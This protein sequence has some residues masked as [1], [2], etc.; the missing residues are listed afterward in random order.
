MKSTVGYS[1]QPMSPMAAVALSQGR[2]ALGAVNL[3]AYLIYISTLP[4]VKPTFSCPT[5]EKLS[6]RGRKT[7]LLPSFWRTMTKR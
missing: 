4:S 1:Q 5:Q 3:V 7:L 6:F 2:H